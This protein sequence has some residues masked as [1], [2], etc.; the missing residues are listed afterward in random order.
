ML[1]VTCECHVNRVKSKPADEIQFTLHRNHILHDDAHV[2]QCRFLVIPEGINN[3]VH[4]YN[5][6]PKATASGVDMIPENTGRR[7]KQNPAHCPG[8]S[9]ALHLLRKTGILWRSCAGPINR[10][11]ERLL[12]ENTPAADDQSHQDD[13]PAVLP[14][15]R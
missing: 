4:L 7:R 6:L 12:A 5:F 8:Q 9:N 11:V 13:F 1:R 10:G 3:P 2:M 14:L 15:T